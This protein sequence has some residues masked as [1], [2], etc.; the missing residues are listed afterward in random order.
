MAIAP[1]ATYLT[2]LHLKEALRWEEVSKGVGHT[3]GTGNL[4]M[5]Q[6]SVIQPCIV[7]VLH[8]SLLPGPATNDVKYRIAGNFCWVQIFAIFADR[9][10][11][12][13]I[14]TAKK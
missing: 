4:D 6:G 12:V 14:K 5:Q 8:T 1:L 11:S 3:R 7:C 13:K 10:T 9:P 2:L